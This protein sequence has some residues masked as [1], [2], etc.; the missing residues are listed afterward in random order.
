MKEKDKS[1]KETKKENKEIKKKGMTL[2]EKKKLTAIIAGLVVIALLCGGLFYMRGNSDSYKYLDYD[3][4]ITLGEYKGLAYQEKEVK[5]TKE[6]ID[7]EIENRLTMAQ[8]AQLIT[9]GKVNDGDV[10]NI[11]YTGKIDGK[12][13]DGGSDEGYDLEIGSE[14]FLKEFEDGLIG[15]NVG[16]TVDIKVTFPKD[17]D[18]ED[19]AGKEAVFTVKIN[20]KLKVETPE[21]DDDFIEY[22]TD[23]DTKEEFE[24]SI[25]KELEKE[26]K[27]ANVEE[28]KQELWEQ[29]VSAS[30][31]KKYPKK[32][33][34]AEKALV[35]A[36]YK[37]VAE[38]YGMEYDDLK[39][40]FG[41]TDEDL[42]ETTKES[43]KEKL[44]VYAV[45]KKEGIRVTDKEYREA[46]DKLLEEAGFTE[47]TFE[48]QYGQT[49]QDYA[50]EQ[51]FRSGMLRDEVSDFIYKNAKVEK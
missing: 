5:V 12:E 16:D 32:Q 26:M 22:N 44:C 42:K 6:D 25:K 27:E 15:K 31:V 20:S 4:Y 8:D 23:Y 9:K 39:E 28:T 33:Y 36:Y 51:D 43:V 18:N 49:I 10:V 3:K 48:E 1:V 13:F 45:A 35:E 7:A 40:Q 38:Q 17:Y 29:V 11:D 24:A 2:K 14:T 46:I 50:K 37:D 41:L 47:E 30:T 19:I 21:Y 34:K